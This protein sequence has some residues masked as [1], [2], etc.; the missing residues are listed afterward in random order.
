MR[1]DSGSFSKPLPPKPRAILLGSQARR[2]DRLVSHRCTN[3]YADTDLR[4]WVQL[5]AGGVYLAA[6]TGM[7]ST[8]CAGS[9]YSSSQGLLE[10][11]F[12]VS[13][14]CFTMK[15]H[16]E[17]DSEA[18]FFFF[19]HLISPAFKLLSSLVFLWWV[20][21]NFCNPKSEQCCI[22]ALTCAESMCGVWVPLFCQYALHNSH[23][24][25]PLVAKKTVLTLGFD[26]VFTFRFFPSDSLQLLSIFFPSHTALAA[27]SP[28]FFYHVYFALAIQVSFV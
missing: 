26:L 9:F 20:S 24:S 23:Q 15:T 8:E 13:R 6:V 18:T 21:S 25:Q 1:Q 16:M 28:L 12:A 2:R 3:G 19:S 7:K 14:A 11:S 27:W 5:L 22:W 10:P 4:N 17:W